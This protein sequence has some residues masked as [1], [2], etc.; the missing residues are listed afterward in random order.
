VNLKYKIISFLPYL[1]LGVFFFGIIFL[2]IN[3]NL[4]K[5]VY[6][7]ETKT[8]EDQ[9]IQTLPEKIP[10]EKEEAPQE[11][12]KTQPVIVDEI[13]ED[14]E[15]V[16]DYYYTKNGTK[17]HSKPDCRYLKN[18]SIVIR[19]TYENAKSMDLTPCSGCV[20]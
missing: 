5:P 15:N 12:E 4:E 3:G 10:D 18:S 11:S 13:F 20:G 8:E 9:I 6:S 16:T 19:T 17:F 7:N 1:L 2:N 14:S